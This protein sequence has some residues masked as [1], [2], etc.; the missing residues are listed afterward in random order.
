MVQNGLSGNF[1]QNFHFSQEPFAIIGGRFYTL[2][3]SNGING[4]Y[5]FSLLGKAY[6][7]DESEEVSQLEKNFVLSRRTDIERMMSQYIQKNLVDKIQAEES[8]VA[9]LQNY[10]ESAQDASIE[11]FIVADVFNAYYHEDKTSDCTERTTADLSLK[12]NNQPSIKELLTADNSLN[13]LTQ[14]SGFMAIAGRCYLLEECGIK[15]E[16]EGYV[17]FGKRAFRL[18][19]WL[20]L[21]ELCKLYGAKL[22]ERIEKKAAEHGQRFAP[23]LHEL[24]RQK[25]ELLEQNKRA[26]SDTASLGEIAFSKI[27]RN[28]Y[29]ISVA[30]PPYI[31][32]K[33]G[34]YYRFEAVRI[35]T[36][37]TAEN[38]LVRIKGPPKILSGQYTHPFVTGD[39]VCYGEINWASDPGVSFNRSYRLSERKKTAKR[40]AEVIRRGKLTL[41]F[42]YL[43]KNVLAWHPIEDC[44]CEI[45]SSRADAERYARSQGI[46]LE[47]ICKNN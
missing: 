22:A 29:E 31:I 1:L 18:Q 26:N 8:E 4:H 15:N 35:G 17:A 28:E 32:E 13:P 37:I 25:K 7:L 42:G 19:Q 16:R 20:Q 41:E 3:R 5:S 9:R 47:R 34:K 36:A 24:S 6:A 14:G 21:E 40:I 10:Y 46:S 44:N 38:G 12:V 27:G 33:K 43:G 30:L 39:S 11:R 23:I 45:A 2:S